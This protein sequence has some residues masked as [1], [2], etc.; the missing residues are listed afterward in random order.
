[1]SLR[2]SKFGSLV[3][4]L[5]GIGNH[6]HLITIL[7]PLFLLWFVMFCPRC[8]SR[9]S[10]TFY[11]H[12]AVLLRLTTLKNTCLIHF[13]FFWFVDIPIHNLLVHKNSTGCGANIP[14]ATW[15]V[16]NLQN[17]IN[18]YVFIPM[19]LD[20]SRRSVSSGPTFRLCLNV[21]VS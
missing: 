20:R 6:R 18:E 11:F 12:S 19:T 3:L 10:C 15:I 21:L 8:P 4:Y 7:G 9:T 13:H 1:M 16:S 2:Y 14:S 17:I 5:Q